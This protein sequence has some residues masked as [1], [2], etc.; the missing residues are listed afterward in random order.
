VIAQSMP[1]R[2]PPSEP[3]PPLLSTLPAKIAEPYATPYRGPDPGAFGPQAVPMQCVPC[4]WPSCGDSPGMKDCE[5]TAL[6]TKSGCDESKPV[7]STATE[8]P[9]P[10]NDD[11]WAFVAWMPQVKSVE[12]RKDCTPGSA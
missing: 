11:S 10:E 8:I 12:S 5:V 7:S 6:P 1:A 2:I 3:D 9:C 4:P